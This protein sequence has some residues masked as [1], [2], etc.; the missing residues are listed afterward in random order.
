MPKRK[1]KRRKLNADINIVPYIDV[2]LVLLIIFMVTAPLMHTGVDI[3]LPQVAAKS[4]ETTEQPIVVSLDGA[5]N[6]FLTLGSGE[7]Q[8]V[9][10]ET[11]VRKVRAFENQNPGIPVM[12]GGD[13]QVNYGKVMQ[14]MV[15]LQQAG[16]PNVGLMTTPPESD[17]DRQ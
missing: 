12:F 11:L 15:L 5:G 4:L 3:T 6:L 9:D 16:V 1:R 2:M 14:A 8:Q 17:V 7:R 13:Q 10:A